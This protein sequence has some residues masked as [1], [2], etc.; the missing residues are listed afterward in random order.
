MSVTLQYAW[1]ALWLNSDLGQIEEIALLLKQRKC[2]S[3]WDTLFDHDMNSLV[4]GCTDTEIYPHR[5]HKPRSTLA[6]CSMTVSCVSIPVSTST[7]MGYL[8]AI[9][10]FRTFGL[11]RQ[12]SCCFLCKF[13]GI[14]CYNRYYIMTA[15]LRYT[16][17]IDDSPNPKRYW[18]NPAEC[19]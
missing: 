1:K 18:R 13:G 17:Y 14:S 19:G 11:F 5:H 15:S 7:N 16:A 2:F 9:F 3:M 6:A 4:N 12:S 10:H 8:R